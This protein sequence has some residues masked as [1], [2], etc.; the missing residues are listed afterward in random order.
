MVAMAGVKARKFLRFIGEIELSHT[1][2]PRSGILSVVAHYD[3]IL[4]LSFGG[5]EKPEDVIPFLENVLRGRNIPRARLLQVAEH[6]YLFGGKSPINDQ[7]R[8]LIAALQ[9]ELD[10]HGPRLPIYWGNR[11]WH[12]ML[13]DTMR[14]MTNDGI[15]NALV[16]VTSAY[17]SY[18]GCRQYREDIDRARL[19]L[20]GAPTCEKLRH[21]CRHPGFL[22]PNIEAVRD[23][24]AQAPGAPILFTA[25]SVPVEMANSSKYVEQLEFVAHAVATATS[26]SNYRLVYQSRSGPP[27]QPWLEPDILK[28]LDETK[29]AGHDSVVVSPIGFTSDHMEVIYD[30]DHEAAHHAASIGL[31]MVRAATVGTHPRFI[32]M[33]RELINERLN[34]TPDAD[35]C[36]ED[37]CPAPIRP[38]QPQA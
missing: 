27:H 11:N 5:P 2:P 17:S 12:P 36:R 24:L 22:E 1:R 10:S 19:S 35:P 6:Y 31:R 34:D 14:Q 7:C 20:I 26:P 23:A 15:R 32:T 29:A 28:A 38:A 16:F 25:H 9:A 21:Y 4:L 33:I 18:S 30:L 37:C 3:A 8:A 13:A